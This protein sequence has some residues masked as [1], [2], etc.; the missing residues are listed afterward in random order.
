[1]KTFQQAIEKEVL[2]I[3]KKHAVKVAPGDE[4]FWEG[5]DIVA[6]K[7]KKEARMLEKLAN[8][9]EIWGSL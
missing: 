4:G 8:I 7:S 3:F 6:T 2:R 1:M 9:Y 5:V